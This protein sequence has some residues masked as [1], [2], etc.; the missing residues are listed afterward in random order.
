MKH[1][2]ISMALL[3][4][5]IVWSSKNPRVISEK[6]MHPQRVTVCCGFWQKASYFFENEKAA[7]VNCSISRDDNTVLSAEIG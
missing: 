4:T 6:Q 1:I 3:I 7:T 2:F 5:K